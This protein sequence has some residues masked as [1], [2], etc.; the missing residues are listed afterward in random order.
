MFIYLFNA[1]DYNVNITSRRIKKRERNV[2]LSFKEKHSRIAPTRSSSK[3]TDFII[4]IE[5]NDKCFFLVP[6]TSQNVAY[7]NIIELSEKIEEFISSLGLKVL[8]YG[9]KL[10][11]V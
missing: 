5:K 11:I 6:R 4:Q 8:I 10:Q 3:C 7:L 2:I 1:Y 9:T